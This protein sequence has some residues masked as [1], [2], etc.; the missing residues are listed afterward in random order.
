MR[1]GLNSRSCTSRLR[2]TRTSSY[3]Y[4]NFVSQGHML[5]GRLWVC[6]P[7]PFNWVVWVVHCSR[8]T[9]SSNPRSSTT[10]RSESECSDAVRAGVRTLQED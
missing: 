4:A 5:T 9:T 7:L 8:A 2:S 6:Q 1:P 3:N 10:R